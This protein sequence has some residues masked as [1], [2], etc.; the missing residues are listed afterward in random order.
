MPVS[1]RGNSVNMSPALAGS[2]ILHVGLFVLVLMLGM[3]F[4][5]PP[6]APG[7]VPVTIVSKGPP[8]FINAPVAETPQEAQAEDVDVLTDETFAEPDP[9]PQPTAAKPSARP[10]PSPLGKGK[11]APP[12][13]LDLDRLLKDVQASRTR[14]TRPPPATTQ[15]PA[16]AAATIKVGSGKKL[17]GAT[18][19]YLLTLGDE[20][21]RRWRPN[22]YAEGASKVKVTLTFIIGPG[23]L[24]TPP[25]PPRDYDR[26]K[27]SAEDAAYISARR[28]V[29]AARY[30]DFP[31]EL[32]GEE[33]I[34]PFDA[35]AV[36]GK[37]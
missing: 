21:G 10:A 27:P 16:K 34:V 5:K 24:I 17:S 32:Y 19:G 20:L 33:L 28:A 8:E 12:S 26:N 14:R 25:P 13:D 15:G 9:L 2:L 36:C 11:P 7:G 37:Q 22:C 30:E 23:G 29:F 4:K 3:Y 1:R 35:A 31:P 6:L 18:K